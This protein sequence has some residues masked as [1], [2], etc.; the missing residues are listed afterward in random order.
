MVTRCSR[1]DHFRDP[2]L[3]ELLVARGTAD[4]RPGC[5]LQVKKLSSKEIDHSVRG[6]RWC[7]RLNCF[8]LALLIVV[9][10]GVVG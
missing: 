4:S 2:E 7:K 3:V 10:F 5:R 1:F 8:V 6:S 9:L